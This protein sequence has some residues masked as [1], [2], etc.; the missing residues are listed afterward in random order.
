M[1]L[2]GKIN[3]VAFNYQDW[4]YTRDD[5]KDKFWGEKNCIALWLSHKC[6]RQRK[7]KGSR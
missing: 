7:K 1:C 2:V 3:R 4:K 6:I 5:G